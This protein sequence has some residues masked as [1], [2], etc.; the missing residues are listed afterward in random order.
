LKGGRPADETISKRLRERLDRPNPRVSVGKALRGLATAMIDLS[1]GLGA[2]LGHILKASG[3][4]AE[5]RLADLPLS[6]DV[7]AVVSATGDWSL[8]LSSGD[9]YE[10][11]FTF[12]NERVGELE[13]LA[14]RLNCALTLIGCITDGD[15][16]VF[17]SS[18]GTVWVP[19]RAGY[20]HFSNQGA[21]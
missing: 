14:R 4:G 19:Q 11:C 15:S 12:P 16:V 21:G 2:D 18:D 20:D 7:T 3:V 6:Q 5:V 10:L 8:P 9:D 13:G 17:R 1:D